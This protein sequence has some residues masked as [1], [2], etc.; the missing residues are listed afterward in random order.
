MDLPLETVEDLRKKIRDLIAER[1]QQTIAEREQQTREFK[2]LRHVVEDL[3]G[4]IAKLRHLEFQAEERPRRGSEETKDTHVRARSAGSLFT[5]AL[6][7]RRGPHA[8]ISVWVRHANTGTLT[9]LL[10]EVEPVLARLLGDYFEDDGS[11][12]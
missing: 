4:A 3:Q 5:S 2:A 11:E 12:S 1:N 7:T 6:V 9:V 8:W 10:E